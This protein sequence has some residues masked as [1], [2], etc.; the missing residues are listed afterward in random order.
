MVW[1]TGASLTGT[2]W[3]G[4]I[5]PASVLFACALDAC[6]QRRDCRGTSSS[7]ETAE[8]RA[9]LFPGAS[10][11]LERSPVPVTMEFL[12]RASP[13]GGTSPGERASLRGRTQGLALP[14][15]S[16]LLRSGSPLR[17]TRP[18]SPGMRHSLSSLPDR[19]DGDVDFDASTASMRSSMSSV[20][21]ARGPQKRCVPPAPFPSRPLPE[22]AIVCT[23]ASFPRKESQTRSVP[24]LPPSSSF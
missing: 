17:A 19:R 1:H 13:L 10:K 15:S 9:A 22:L 23:Q 3:G 5:R 24:V 6:E 18:S 21:G 7:A 2:V 16:P 12:G 11:C 14:S 20:V 4:K 8:A